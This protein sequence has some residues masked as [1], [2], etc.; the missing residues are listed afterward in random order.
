M[1][2]TDFPDDDVQTV[3]ELGARA[4]LKAAL[5]DGLDESVK[6][7]GHADAV[8]PEPGH[9]L[10]MVALD[11]VAPGTYSGSRTITITV[12]VAVAKTTPGAADDAL[13]DR[14][15]DVLD[16]LDEIAWLSWSSAKRAVYLPSED[17]AGFPAF[18]IT[19]TI[20]VH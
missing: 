11:E 5:V 16:V 18:T 3:E 13:E 4:Q 20:E 19:T 6:V 1:S 8:S 10:V 2:I 12:W 9:D 17:A 14:L 7:V 15:G